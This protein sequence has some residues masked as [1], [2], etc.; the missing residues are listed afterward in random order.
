L[1]SS[2]N[3]SSMPWL[4]LA[5]VWKCLAPTDFAYLPTEYEIQSIQ[6]WWFHFYEQIVPG[7]FHPCNNSGNV[8]V[9]RSKMNNIRLVLWVPFVNLL[10]S[11]LGTPINIRKESV[12]A[13]KWDSVPTH[14]WKEN[15]IYKLPAVLLAPLQTFP[16]HI[17]RKSLAVNLLLCILNRNIPLFL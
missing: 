7:S 1:L 6:T 13:F 2:K 3:I 4:S 14:V 17:F 9:K 12:L 5:D 10:A 8:T 11:Q 15:F 16:R